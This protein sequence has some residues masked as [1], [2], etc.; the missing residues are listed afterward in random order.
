MDALIHLAVAKCRL[1]RAQAAA[2]LLETALVRCR[3][4][5][6]RIGE[7]EA[8]VARSEVMVALGRPDEARASCTSGLD[9]AERTGDVELQA[10]ARRGVSNIA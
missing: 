5:G 9:L 10:R 7:A 6:H 1:A 2:G 3:E 8:L 4:L